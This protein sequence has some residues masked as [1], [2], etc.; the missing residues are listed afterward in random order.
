MRNI[1]ILGSFVLVFYHSEGLKEKTQANTNNYYYLI[2]NVRQ[3][4]TIVY[5]RDMLK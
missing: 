2:L 5:K 4:E 1:L 3:K